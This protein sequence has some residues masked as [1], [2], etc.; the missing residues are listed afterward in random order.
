MYKLA[1]LKPFMAMIHSDDI[2]PYTHWAFGDLD[3]CFG[4]MRRILNEVNLSKYDLITTHDFHIAGHFTVMRNNDYFRNLCL[5][6]PNWRKLLEYPG[7]V[8]VDEIHWSN[9]VFPSLKYPLF[10][11]NKI[12]KRIFPKSFHWLM[13][14]WNKLANP[15]VLFK[16]YYTS[17]EPKVGEKWLYDIG[18]GAILDPSDRELPYLHFLFFKGHPNPEHPKWNNSYYKLNKS[19]IDYSKI[20]I[21]TDSIAGL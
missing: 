3:L 5:D 4:D 13:N 7:N 12:L 6:I 21:S 11:Y 16:E 1:D 9:V 2:A 19:L 15:K 17:P 18:S 20:L 8:A 14:S 10:F